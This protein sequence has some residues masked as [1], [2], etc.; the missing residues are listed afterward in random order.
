[1][2]CYIGFHF[3][4]VWKRKFRRSGKLREFHFA[5]FVSTLIEQYYCY[6]SSSKDRAVVMQADRQHLQL[7]MVIPAVLRP[8]VLQPTVIPAVQQPTVIPAVQQP[9][10]MPAVQQPMVMP[11]LLR[12]VGTP[13]VRR[14][15]GRR[16][17]TALRLLLQRRHLARHH[18]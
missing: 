18:T 1:M 11:A 12:T 16:L 3:I 13:V 8:T 10:V 4:I 5:K 14:C 9:M 6:Y 17:H 2:I 15:V 7:H